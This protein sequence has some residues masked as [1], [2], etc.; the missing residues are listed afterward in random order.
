MTLRA[1]AGRFPGIPVS[2]MAQYTPWGLAARE[3]GVPGYP[4]LSRPITKRELEK[5][6]GEL[7]ALGLDGFVQS[8]KAK[9]EGF[10]PDFHQ[11]GT[12]PQG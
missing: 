3:G 12:Q 5:V 6:Q 1:I 8:R 4:E 9:G 7:F 2:L 10:I 11:F